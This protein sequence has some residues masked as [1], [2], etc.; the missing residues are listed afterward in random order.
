MTSSQAAVEASTA[1][2]IAA[3]FALVAMVVANVVGVG[4]RE[5]L[6]VLL[7]VPAVRNLVLVARGTPDERKWAGGGLVVMVIVLVVV[8]RA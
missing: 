5:A 3:S 1:A 2:A 7:F 8:M 6:G 4:A